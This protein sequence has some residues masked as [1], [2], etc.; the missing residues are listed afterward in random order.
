VKDVLRARHRW[1]PYPTPETISQAWVAVNAL[2][3]R[4]GL[5]GFVWICD[6]PPRRNFCMTMA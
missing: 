3:P 4:V 2:R 1:F 6:F 5:G